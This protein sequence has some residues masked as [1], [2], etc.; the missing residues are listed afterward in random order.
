[1]I[2]LSAQRFLWWIGGFDASILLRESCRPVRPKYSA[3]G[4]LVLMTAVL[5]ACSG[6][7]AVWT[8]FDSQRA[9]VLLGAS[10]G[11]FILFLDRFLVSS[12]RKL[13]T[14]KEF[15]VGKHT[16]P[17]YEPQGA[18]GPIVVRLCLAFAIG[19][20]ASKPIEVRLLKPW[21]VEHEL[22]LGRQRTKD[23]DDTPALARQR[24]D[25]K[26]AQARVSS[27]LTEVEKLRA[28]VSGEADGTSGTLKRGVGLIAAKKQELYEAAKAEATSLQSDL[29]A[30][31][32]E[33]K[34]ERDA[35]MGQTQTENDSL[36]RDESVIKALRDIHQLSTS[37]DGDAGLVSSVSWALILLFVLIEST[38]V[39]AKAFSTT[40]PYDA[41]L[42]EVEHCPILDSLARVMRKHE[43]IMTHNSEQEDETVLPGRGSRRS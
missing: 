6:G 40:D 41:A 42:Q 29:Q 3:M 25:I 8:I 23:T 7:Y 34:S 31:E 26:E 1:M 4:A 10:W 5:A 16:A 38:P 36:M 14:L 11:M 19:L 9:A 20:I 27:K 28:D 33:Y 37:G 32:Q 21:I 30:K 43:E 35:L 13:A 22:Q 15:F 12:T 39:L 17:P 24:T 2:V 18:W